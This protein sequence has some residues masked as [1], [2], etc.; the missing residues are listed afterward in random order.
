MAS[1]Y[2]K[3]KKIY[4]SWYDFTLQKNM[5]KSLGL[6]N[7]SEN[8]KKAKTIAREFEKELK[9]EKEKYKTLGIGR[10]TIHYAFNHF[11][12]N[13]QHKHPKTKVDYM[14]FYSMFIKTFP[15][16]NSCSIITKLSVENWLNK[17]KQLKMKKN[18][19]F[20]YYRQMNHFLNF[21]F[22]YNYIPMFKINRDVKPKLEIGE[23]IIIGLEDLAVIFSMLDKAKKSESFK[24]LIAV[25]YYTG[26]RASD[27]ISIKVE[28]INLRGCLLKYYSPKRKVNR[29][30]AFHRDLLPIFK[31]IKEEHPEGKLLDYKNGESLQRAISRYFDVIDLKD[32]KYTSR[33]FR[34]TFITIARKNGM[35]ESVVK[36]LVGH[37]H[38]STTDRF[39]NKIDTDQMSKELLKYISVKDL[40]FDS[41]T[42]RV[43]KIFER[44][45]GKTNKN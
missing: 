25:L 21:L 23:K 35:D 10:N 3:G 27:L 13:N 8:M 15:E 12:K 1:I 6:E 4:I 17:I 14:R 28:D 30:I 16:E 20:G 33:S 22:E 40:P 41:V 5:N 39:Y 38:T 45:Q 18:S 26:L 19:I 29:E 24:T 36:E 37:A 31:R 2:P 7:N 43:K 9:K 34:K 44:L 42:D 32:R 11:L